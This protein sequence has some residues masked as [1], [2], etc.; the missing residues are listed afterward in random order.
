MSTAAHMQDQLRFFEVGEATRSAL[1]EAW[2]IV[3]PALP[4]V[5]AA[6]YGHVGGYPELAT[7]LGAQQQRLS[8]A[9][10]KHWERL[11]AASFDQDY[12][13]SVQRIGLAHVKIGL[14]PRWYIGAYAFVM[15]R[16]VEVIGRSK[17]F[18]GPK[19][20]RLVAEVQKV[21]CL[22]MNFALAVYQQ[23]LMDEVKRKAQTVENEVSA[24]DGVVRESL[25]AVGK[26]AGE[27]KSAADTLR[28]TADET[29][30]RASTVSD[31]ARATLENVQTGATAT[32]ELSASI[33]E[34]GSQASKSLEIAR[35][36]VADA[37]RTTGS[38][39]SLAEAAQRI[40]SV[41]SLISDIAEQTN[42][43]A[44]NATIE[45]ARAGE[46]GRGFAVVAQ[47]VKSLAGQTAKATDE[48]STQISAVQDLT[49]RSVSD[50]ESIGSIIGSVAEIATA[51]AS[52]VEEQTAATRE[53][54]QN[55]QGAAAASAT[56]TGAIADVSAGSERTKGAAATVLDGAGVVAERAAMLNGKLEEFFARLR[57]A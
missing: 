13:E 7:K 25:G 23:T 32:E 38:V 27:L 44:L 55:V 16:L 6:F 5:L 34:I 48:I 3:K 28:R 11:F 22:D 54:A 10:S 35:R 52:A 19:A 43:L 30:D 31:S 49:R 9:Q 2:A 39:R 53:I 57:A 40:G 46:A 41:V 56:T 15:S 17:R 4:Q 24:F 37:E 42:L 20:A 18:S 36:A 50:I 12:V 14:E 26:A 8:S 47:E 21:V 29:A 51:I 45:A 33:A 1:A